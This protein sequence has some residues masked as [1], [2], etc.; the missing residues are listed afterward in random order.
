MKI[1]SYII[2]LILLICLLA[3]IAT[4]CQSSNALYKSNKKHYDT[5]H[6]DKVGR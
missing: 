4:A 6:N 3:A 5:T 2:L 1:L